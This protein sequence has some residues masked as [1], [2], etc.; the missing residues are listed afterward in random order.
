VAAVSGIAA[1]IAM[2]LAVRNGTAGVDEM[3]YPYRSFVEGRAALETLDRAA[4]ERA[5]AAFTTTLRLAPESASA[6]IALAHARFLTFESTRASLTPNRDALADAERHAREACQIDPSSADAWGTL[7]L[8]LH[9]RGLRSDGQPAVRESIAGARMAVDLQPREWRH[10]IRLAM[11]GWGDERLGAATRALAL[12]P[13]LAM[14]H[15]FAASV[16]VAREAFGP[17]LDHLRAGCAIHDAN[18]SANASGN[19]ES[20]RFASL[21]LHLLHGLVL[22]VDDRLRDI[23]AAHDELARE[24]AVGGGH[25][26]ARECHAN[27]WYAIGALHLR[28]GKRDAAVAA[29]ESAIAQL[30]AHALAL[31]GLAAA[32]VRAAGPT[33]IA[34]APGRDGSNISTSIERVDAATV[35]A[36][37][38]ALQGDHDQAARVCDEAL[39]GAEQGAAGWLLP[40]EPLLHVSANRD[41]WQRTRARLHNRAS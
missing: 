9:R 14:A 5:T 15:W 12:C 10:H 7:A 11:V 3:L 24:L 2:S 20:A 4:I 6:R 34:S 29:F 19:A 23:D 40:V 27:T 35:R 33:R 17:A 30:P 28:E 22:A 1:N 31:V 18:A 13:G 37:R 39:A 36:A 25:V 32:G 26:Y 38:L 8:V 41:A 16:F 21:G